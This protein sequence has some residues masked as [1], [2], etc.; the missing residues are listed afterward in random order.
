MAKRIDAFIRYFSE[1]FVYTYIMKVSWKHVSTFLTANK[2]EM[3]FVAKR[4]V[5]LKSEVSNLNAVQW[6]RL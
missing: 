4:L 1:V 3:R 6:R 5:L 2:I